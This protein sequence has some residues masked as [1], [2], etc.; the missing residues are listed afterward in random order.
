MK[1]KR[2]FPIFIPK[3]LEESG[4]QQ[5]GATDFLSKARGSANRHGPSLGKKICGTADAVENRF[6]ELFGYNSHLDLAHQIWAKA[7]KPGD[8]AIDATCGNGHDTAFLAKHFAGVIALDIQEQALEN[9]R[10]LVQDCNN[11]HLFH[12]SHETF[13]A[14]PHPIRLIVYNLGYLPGGDKQLTTQA[15][16][17][18]MSIQN[19]LRLAQSL[20]SITCYPG[21][22]E[23]QREEEAILD[24]CQDLPPDMWNVSFHSFRNRIKAPSLV[25]IQKNV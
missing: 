20:I 14:L 22:P 17:T 1:E 5:G 18:L 3:Q 25:V 7:A 24:F 12:Q 9:T 21:H 8:W 10:K 11:V 23:G 2:S 4:I 6:F 13:P 16:S 15:S 19:A